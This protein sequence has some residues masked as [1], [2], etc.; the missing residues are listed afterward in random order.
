MTLSYRSWL[1]LLTLT[2]GLV[3]AACSS[4]STTTPEDDDAGHTPG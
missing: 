2:V 3:I 1:L 4:S